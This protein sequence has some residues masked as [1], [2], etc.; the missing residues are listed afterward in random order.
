MDTEESEI[1]STNFIVLDSQSE[2]QIDA[3][4]AS[5]NWPALR[6][7]N[8]L[9]EDNT[10]KP[11]H[12]KI[13][14]NLGD[15]SGDETRPQGTAD[16]LV[17]DSEM[18]GPS[19]PVS[20]KRDSSSDGRE[21]II[22]ES[23]DA[24][25][26]TVIENPIEE[27]NSGS[28]K[29]EIPKQSSG[30]KSDSGSSF[31]TNSQA[32]LGSYNQAEMWQSQL[33]GQRFP[34]TARPTSPFDLFGEDKEEELLVSTPSEH[35]RS[36]QL[37]NQPILV[38]ETVD[39][40]G[41]VI[42]PSPAVYDTDHIIIPSSPTELEDTSASDHDRTVYDPSELSTLQEDLP[43]RQ[44]E[45]IPRD[46]QKPSVV[47]KESSGSFE[48]HLSLGD[49]EMTE[50][51]QYVPSKV[52]TYV[53]DETSKKEE[54]TSKGE[55]FKLH[56]SETQ[57]QDSALQGGKSKDDS[58]VII[59]TPEKSLSQIEEIEEYEGSQF[60]LQ[61]SPSQ[62]EKSQP[63]S[64]MSQKSQAHVG[65][66]DE[67]A[68][69][70]ETKEKNTES[71]QK[72]ITEP[73]HSNDSTKSKSQELQSGFHLSLPKDGELLHPVGSLPKGA[74]KQIVSLV[75]QTTSQPTDITAPDNKELGSV[76][77]PVSVHHPGT[78]QHTD[79][80]AHVKE[81]EDVRDPVLMHQPG[82]SL[83]EKMATRTSKDNIDPVV[84]RDIP[85]KM[86]VENTECERQVTTEASSRIT[87]L[88]EQSTLSQQA[89]QLERPEIREVITDNSEDSKR[90]NVFLKT[91]SNHSTRLDQ[92]KSS[93][94]HTVEEDSEDDFLRSKSRNRKRYA[95]LE[96]TE[97]QSYLEDSELQ[98]KAKKIRI[99]S[100][101][102]ASQEQPSEKMRQEQYN[103]DTE[104]LT[105]IPEEENRTQPQ[106][107]KTRTLSS[108]VA[109]TGYQ[110]SVEDETVS[111]AQLEK[112][113]EQENIRIDVSSEIMVS[114]EKDNSTE[115]SKI[116]SQDQ[117][118]T[119][120]Y[121]PSELQTIDT[122]YTHSK[123]HSK[124]LSHTNKY[125]S[126]KRKRRIKTRS[127]ASSARKGKIRKAC[128]DANLNNVDD[129]SSQ[130]EIEEKR[131]DPF[132]F[133]GTESQFSP[134][135][136]ESVTKIKDK[137]PTS[138]PR[139]KLATTPL[140][141]RKPKK[142]PASKKSSLRVKHS[143]KME[144]I[145]NQ[146]HQVTFNPVTESLTTP[147]SRTDTYARSSSIG[148]DTWPSTSKRIETYVRPS[149]IGQDTEPSIST[150]TDTYVRPSTIGPYSEPTTS[151]YIR[152]PSIGHITR[153]VQTNTENESIFRTPQNITT[154]AS[155]VE[156]RS[157]FEQSVGSFIPEDRRE[158]RTV[159]VVKELRYEVHEIT[160]EV[161]CNGKVIS[162]KFREEKKG[163]QILIRTRSEEV[164]YITP[165]TSPSRST[166]TMTSGDLGDISSS[167]SRSSDGSRGS[168]RH[169]SMNLGSLERTVSSSIEAVPSIPPSV[170]ELP[171]NTSICTPPNQIL[172]SGEIQNTEKRNLNKEDSV[173][174]T[175]TI[176]SK[177]VSL[178]SDI[179]LESPHNVSVINKTGS[180]ALFTSPDTS[181]GETSDLG[182]DG[183]TG[184]K[185]G[186][187]QISKENLVSNESSQ[188][189]PCAQTK[190]RDSYLSADS[191]SGPDILL[192]GRRNSKSSGESDYF[193]PVIPYQVQAVSSANSSSSKRIEQAASTSAI[194][195]EPVVGSRVMAKWKDGF[196]YPG[197]ISKIDK[198]RYHVKFDDGTS[199]IVKL[200]EILLI[201]IMPEGQ[202]V[203]VQSTDDELG[204]DP[205]IVLNRVQKNKTMY[206]NVE[207]DDG[208]QG[209]YTLSQLV[210]REDQAAFLISTNTAISTTGSP[211]RSP[212]KQKLA[213][214]SLDNLVDGRR[215][216]GS[217]YH[218]QDELVKAKEEPQKSATTSKR[219]NRDDDANQGNNDSEEFME[220]P[221]TSS[222]GRK[223]GPRHTSTPT[224]KG[225]VISSKVKGI[226][227][228]P[229]GEAVQS[230][231]AP[232]RSP[233]KTKIGTCLFD[234]NKKNLFRGM[235]FL[236]TYVQKTPEEIRQEKCLLKDSSSLELSTDESP[237]EEETPVMFDK[238]NIRAEIEA[239]GGVVLQCFDEAKIS[240]ARQCFLL[241]NT[242]QKTLK[243]FQCLAAGIPCVSHVWISDSFAQGRRLD[244]KSYM[245]PAGISLEK[246]KLIEWNSHGS[247]LKGLKV[248]IVSVNRK[249]QEEWSF[250]ME[251]AECQVLNKLPVHGTSEV[252]CVI[253]D[254][255]CPSSVIRKCKQ[256]NVPIVSTQWVI[257]TLIHGYPMDFNGHPRYRYD[258]KEDTR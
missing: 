73:E 204:Y 240:A 201:D 136:E 82:T 140:S 220:K 79:I 206:Y 43:D 106:M 224:P 128:E 147:P 94:L 231:T 115:V 163:P 97:E 23:E 114:N 121:Y 47:E 246:K 251:I 49:I 52:T 179:E 37:S 129:S 109:S 30:Q 102:T 40:D 232:R 75:Q 159:R 195:S 19:K 157:S 225:K 103:E 113:V 22:S 218:Q 211:C 74:E 187:E 46:E 249:F 25:E 5:K 24:A 155:D 123:T 51:L 248:H 53:D 151:T 228:S 70:E 45:N 213:D 208:T 238:D 1:Q 160:E 122:G 254:N 212:A 256:F 197:K 80:P 126:L 50:D 56:Y 150:Q 78:S 90:E 139:S 156:R 42:S 214:V 175:D 18:E 118:S 100:G 95:V 153:S 148:Q 221:H 144:D 185:T 96:D 253:T 237:S 161:W 29:D 112:N 8:T 162:R 245:L 194:S 33:K 146:T 172:R 4:D 62:S 134:E 61:L 31:H 108:E 216:A 64:R 219:V 143:R 196:Y 55:S 69:A 27:K 13:F 105:N 252:Y 168:H 244:Y 59:I 124:T 190:T 226:E 202:P 81:T 174:K 130:N 116:V 200:S 234:S 177:S 20:T 186:K 183:S 258:F 149:F 98:P 77:E 111:T 191:T 48:P 21:V 36:L 247:C 54:Y 14:K 132:D 135:I 63:F 165:E 34:V 110:G 181:K 17:T 178:Q 170:T 171:Q 223:R 198:M 158:L 58:D 192:K 164:T 207:K 86:E 182:K 84:D 203:M 44:K 250:V 67:F 119:V 9:M 35:L 242:Y 15:T 215:R 199:L 85:N 142:K 217:R 83:H 241:S 99:L 92:K 205:G 193:S 169:E 93:K 7:Q 255:S 243:Y 66:T 176:P 101:E 104:E 6:P 173:S 166:S 72:G 88:S 12:T 10:D 152:S 57:A 120:T 3:A 230:P 89:F 133:H 127:T 180:D 131:R 65:T 229:V 154:T 141:S 145:T 71:F 257:Q 125:S 68:V 76:R 91:K 26:V 233:R 188:S 137:N 239:G 222:Q 11:Q 189:I 236:L 41:N 32:G 235:A 107:K 39:E 87:S 138:N 209:Q 167:L 38:P 2:S 16:I 60:R 117:S 28:M 227:A 184:D 210:L